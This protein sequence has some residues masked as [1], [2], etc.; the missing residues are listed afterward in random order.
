[1]PPLLVQLMIRHRAVHLR[2]WLP[3]FLLWLLLLP[4]VLILLPIAVVV[5]ARADRHPV[6]TIT[7][8]LGVLSAISGSMIDIERPNAALFVRF[9]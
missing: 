1:M 2:L 9:V 4:L 5:M 6:R 7:A 8:L 3:L